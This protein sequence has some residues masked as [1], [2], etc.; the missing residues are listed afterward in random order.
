MYYTITSYW[1]RFDKKQQ[2]I[3]LLVFLVILWSMNFMDYG[4]FRIFNL[5]VSSF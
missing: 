1:R 3:I 5:I 4:I 2:T